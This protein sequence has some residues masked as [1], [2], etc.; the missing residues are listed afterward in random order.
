MSKP[1][2]LTVVEVELSFAP[3]S[4]KASTHTLRSVTAV[5]FDVADRIQRYL[6]HHGVNA[7]VIVASELVSHDVTN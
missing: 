3:T 7:K 1:S 6:S 2:D 5:P 4:S